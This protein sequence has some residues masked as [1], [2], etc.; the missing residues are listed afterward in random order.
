[1]AQFSRKIRPEIDLNEKY[2]RQKHQ[3]RSKGPAGGF[4]NH[5]NGNR[6]HG[7][8]QGTGF[9]DTEHGVIHILIDPVADGNRY[10][11]DTYQVID[12]GAI[13][14]RPSGCG[15]EQID[16]NGG[17][18]QVESP[19]GFGGNHTE[20]GCIHVPAGH[21]N[22]GARKEYRPEPGKG[23]IPALYFFHP[24]QIGHERVPPSYLDVEIII[25]IDRDI[26]Q[27]A[28]KN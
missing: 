11:H 23:S 3:N 18:E 17:K 7:D 2:D 12:T 9:G 21:E 25:P 19:I 16:K 24:V 26:S 4:H 10:Q 5:H 6:A 8:I 15:K 14:G 28:D 22:G 1:M 27:T 20:T 13:F